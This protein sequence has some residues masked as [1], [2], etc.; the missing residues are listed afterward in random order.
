MTMTCL[1]T[2]SATVVRIGK[3][4]YTLFVLESALYLPGLEKCAVHLSVAI[5]MFQTMKEMC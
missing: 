2:A 1:Y 4:N 3:L 5:T